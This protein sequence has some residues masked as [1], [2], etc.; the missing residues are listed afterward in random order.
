MISAVSVASNSF[1][2][3][4]SSFQCSAPLESALPAASVFAS[5]IMFSASS[6]P[7]RPFSSRSMVD[8]PV[9]HGDVVFSA[10][11]PE[12]G[13]RSDR[14][15]F[16]GLALPV[17]ASPDR[18]KRHTPPFQLH[19]LLGVRQSYV[20]KRTSTTKMIGAAILYTG[21]HSLNSFSHVSIQ[22]FKCQRKRLKH[23]I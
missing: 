7:G 3:A 8:P 13:S 2:R 4:H 21:A 10:L 9:V 16:P 18:L 11:V 23:E 5:M 6:R 15:L 12:L 17:R 19:H 14:K 22:S 1:S 20:Q